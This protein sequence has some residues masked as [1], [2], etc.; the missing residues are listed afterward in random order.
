[1]RSVNPRKGLVALRVD[2]RVFLRLN[3]LCETEFGLSIG[4]LRR[5]VLNQEIGQKCPNALPRKG[6]KSAKKRDAFSATGRARRARFLAR[7]TRDHGS[8]VL[9][10]RS[11]ARARVDSRDGRSPR[12]SCLRE[13]WTASIDSRPPARKVHKRRL[14]E[15]VGG[16]RRA[17]GRA[18]R[19][20]D[21]RSDV[22]RLSLIHISRCR[23]RG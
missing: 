12:E 1:M 14:Q 23:R 10:R 4:S 17:P 3:A 18:A 13:L 11:R 19:D 20:A 16:R 7:A 2:F 9:E 15:D 5:G 22:L 8:G 21:A 6:A